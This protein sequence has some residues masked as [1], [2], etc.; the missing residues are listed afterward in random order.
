MVSQESLPGPLTSACPE[1]SLPSSR[2]SAVVA[3]FPPAS[4]PSCMGT[5][6]SLRGGL[7]WWASHAAAA[8]RRRGRGEEMGR[9]TRSSR[10]VGGPITRR[11][12]VSVSVVSTSAV[13]SPAWSRRSRR[14]WVS[15]RFPLA[16][17]TMLNSGP[18]P[19]S[20]PLSLGLGI[21]AGLGGRRAA[22]SPSLPSRLGLVHCA[23]LGRGALASPRSTRKF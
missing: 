13:S 11:L 23:F 4:D 19:P 1:P 2:G 12:L 9:L 5:T 14:G 15:V 18:P 16:G 3:H 7:K 17:L 6:W 20:P 10:E 22:A 21:A 8:D